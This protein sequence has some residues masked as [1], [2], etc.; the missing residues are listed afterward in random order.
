[1]P[2]RHLKVPPR[3]TCFLIVENNAGQVLLERRPP[4]GIWG[5]LWCF[6][7]VP[8]EDGLA[9]RLAALGLSDARVLQRLPVIAHSFTHFHLDIT[10]L[11]I[12]S[13]NST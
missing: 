13:E 8:D 11:H 2:P 7:E 10:P 12:C 6:P 9:A 1:M 3:S 4:R 5:G